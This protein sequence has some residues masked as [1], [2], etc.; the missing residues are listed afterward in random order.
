MR[1]GALVLSLALAGCSSTDEAGPACAASQHA[2]EDRCVSAGVPLDGCATGFSPD[3][4]GCAPILPDAECASGT[5]PV[6]GET[7]CRP[8]GVQACAEGF[9]ATTDGSCRVAEPTCG[10]GQAAWLGETACHPLACEATTAASV[11]VRPSATSGDGSIDKP[12]GTIAEA[13][14]AAAPGAVVSLAAGTYR[15]IVKVQKPLTLSAPCPGQVSIEPPAGATDPVITV[16]ADGVKL[17][18]LGVG[19]ATLGVL[20]RG[21]NVVLSRVRVHDTRQQGV[22]VEKGSLSARELLVERAGR[23]GFYVDGGKATLE[24]A[25]LRDSGTYGLSAEVDTAGTIADVTAR[26]VVITGYRTAGARALGS[27]LTL[28]RVAVVGAVATTD[29]KLGVGVRSESTSAH[30]ANVT[31]RDVL[32]ARARGNGLL[33]L[34]GTIDAQRLVVRE[35]VG[36]G[37]DVAFQGGRASELKL[38]DSVVESSSGAGLRVAGS[39]ALI[40]RSIVRDL[41]A[42]ADGL[43]FGEGIVALLDAPSGREAELRVEDSVVERTHGLGVLVFGS[44]AHLERVAVRDIEPHTDGRFGYGI[45]AAPSIETGARARLTV[46]QSIVAHA[47]HGGIVVTHSDA[48]LEGVAVS[49][50]RPVSGRFG[51]G[52]DVGDS[53]PALSPSHVVLTGAWIARATEAGVFAGRGSVTL[54]R[55]TILDTRAREDGTFGDGVLLAFG[56]ALDVRGSKIAGNA[57]AGLSNFA[58]TATIAATLFA[59]NAFALDVEHEGDAAPKTDDGGDNACGCGGGPWPKC[60]ASSVGLEPVDVSETSAR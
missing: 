60:K 52:V 26:D 28:E 57:R 8:V 11:Y 23:A 21:V 13:L 53:Q 34:G 4:S 51:R 12:F 46:L 54:E 45:E 40:Q 1:L 10:D 20:S 18:G 19:N 22:Y 31:L 38:S 16:E 5:M 30:P 29:S 41:V 37:L 32:V 42:S 44:P 2:V 36:S 15:E 58:S 55:C 56:G 25:Y 17:V 3:A 59:C 50:P 39:K 6:L 43:R 33:A 14:A 9:Q 27:W 7:A 48:N 47:S 24:R 35:I 49:E